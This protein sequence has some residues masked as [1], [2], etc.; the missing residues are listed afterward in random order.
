MV[1]VIIV[2]EREIDRQ[3]DLNRLYNFE[4]LNEFVIK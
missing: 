1:V 2:G 4:I 3:R